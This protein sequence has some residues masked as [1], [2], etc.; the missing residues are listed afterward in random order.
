MTGTKAASLRESEK[1]NEYLFPTYD[2]LKAGAVC[3]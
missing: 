1:L 3:Y 2:Y